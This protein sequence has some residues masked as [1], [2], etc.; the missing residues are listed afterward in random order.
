MLGIQREGAMEDKAVEILDSHRTM[1]ISTVRPDG[2]P[3]TT[4]V[5]YANDG[6]LIYFL[7][8]RKSQKLANIEHEERVAIAVGS[9]PKTMNEAQAVY[10]GALA[11]EVTDPK[12]RD[13]AWHLLTHRHPNLAGFDPP[14]KSDAAVMRAMCKYVSI[15]DF[16]QGLGHTDGL[17]VGDSGISIMDP[18]RTDDWG[19][20]AAARKADS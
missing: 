11:S 18:A 16:T 5:G 10:A 14:T 7:I 4:I 12:Q 19:L 2:W 6:L 3:Q 17:T 20:S 13:H 9:E 8:S 15:L 1:A